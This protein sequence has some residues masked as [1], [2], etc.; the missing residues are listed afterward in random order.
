M[1]RLLPLTALC[2]I[3]IQ[4][5]EAQTVRTEHVLE[6]DEGAQ[7]PPAALEDMAW[8]AGAWRGEGFGGAIEEVWTPPSNGSMAGLFKLSHDGR[9]SIYEIQTITVENGSLVW[10]VKHFGGDFV[11]W[12]E[13]DGFVAFP[14]VKMES[15]AA[16]F[17]GMT[18]RRDGENIVVYL[19][20][21]Q[22]GEVREERLEYRPATIN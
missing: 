12:E 7:S 14:L 5:S 8:L 15:D 4:S 22:G 17:D 3:M 1:N 9:P 6:L 11:A 13:K 2:L 16:Y 20:A 21:S 19:I 18:L 10:K